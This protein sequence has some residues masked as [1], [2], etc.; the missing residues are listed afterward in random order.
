MRK[1]TL[2]NK[3]TRYILSLLCI[4]ISSVQA[5]DSTTLT[6]SGDDIQASLQ[7]DQFKSDLEEKGDAISPIRTRSLVLTKWQAATVLTIIVVLVAGA[8][9][10]LSAKKQIKPQEN[11]EVEEDLETVV[12]PVPVDADEETSQCRVKKDKATTK[13]KVEDYL[14]SIHAFFKEY[15]PLYVGLYGIYA[16]LQR[17]GIIPFIHSTSADGKVKGWFS[18]ASISVLASVT[19]SVCSAYLV[20]CYVVRYWKKKAAQSK[21]NILLVGGTHQAQ[22]EAVYGARNVWSTVEVDSLNVVPGTTTPQ[23]ASSHD[24]KTSKDK[25]NTLPYALK[26]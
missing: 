23:K 15:G 17:R 10:K 8:Y 6:T 13:D 5:E 2:F 12:V 24:E 20:V 11:L 18:D 9:W 14:K 16:S 25:K 3:N 26:I 19:F 1:L 7:H 22:V 4:C 21:A